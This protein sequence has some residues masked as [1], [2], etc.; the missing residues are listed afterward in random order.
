MNLVN[1][2]LFPHEVIH[3]EDEESRENC[4]RC[5]HTAN[6]VAVNKIILC[7]LARKLNEKLG[8]SIDALILVA[9]VNILP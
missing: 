6:A 4:Y 5:N 2:E 9:E 7:V 3:R 1:I 8:I